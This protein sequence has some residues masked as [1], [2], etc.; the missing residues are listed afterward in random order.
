MTTP[1]RTFIVRVYGGEVVIED[2]RGH[3]RARVQEIGAV[4]AQ[5]AIWLSDGAAAG[6]PEIAAETVGPE[7][8][9]DGA[10]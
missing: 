10:A 2:V 7:V 4:G 9:G 1:R 5:I 8:R 6:T 3:R